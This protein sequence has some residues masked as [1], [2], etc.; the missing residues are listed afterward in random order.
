M[1]T[2]SGAHGIPV[3]PFSMVA[4][5]D[6]REKLMSSRATNSA[7]QINAPTTTR[8]DTSGFSLPFPNKT[9]QR[10]IVNYVVLVNELKE[11]TTLKQPK[12]C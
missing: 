10:Q 3:I 5:R 11:I 7:T 6:E 2:S 12:P 9:L 8:L 4:L 1:I